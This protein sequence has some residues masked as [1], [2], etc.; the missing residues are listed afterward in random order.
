LRGDVYREE[1]VGSV[2]DQCHA[3]HRTGQVAHVLLASGCLA[4]PRRALAS[5]PLLPCPTGAADVSP[6]GTRTWGLDARI[7]RHRGTCHTQ[8]R[9]ASGSWASAP[10]HLLIS[11][12]GNM[13]KSCRLRWSSFPA[14]MKH[15]CASTYGGPCTNARD[16]ET[17]IRAVVHGDCDRGGDFQCLALYND[18]PPWGDRPDS[19]FNLP[20][21][22]IRRPCDTDLNVG[23]PRRRTLSRHQR[24]SVHFQTS[25]G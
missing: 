8:S 13:R 4:Q 21:R 3:A 19:Q 2:R 7:L 11:M 16:G 14:E 1:A 25:H 12:C 24:R 20:N 23:S 9:R 6:C 17:S 22:R 18:E 10:G 5:R 15:L